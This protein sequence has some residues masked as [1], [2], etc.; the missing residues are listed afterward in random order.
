MLPSEIIESHA[1]EKIIG[2]RSYDS[3]VVNWKK[4]DFETH[5]KDSYEVIEQI[6]TTEKGNK[7][8]LAILHKTLERFV[9]GLCESITAKYVEGVIFNEKFSAY[10][11]YYLDITIWHKVK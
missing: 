11:T 4:H 1:K 2:N 3:L 5:I 10:R 9:F 8:Y 7:K 6:G